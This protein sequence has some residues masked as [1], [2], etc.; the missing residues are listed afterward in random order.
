MVKIPPGIRRSDRSMRRSPGRSSAASPGPFR[1]A[2]RLAFVLSMT[3][4]AACD[5]DANAVAPSD[6][7]SVT[8]QVRIDGAPSARS[9]V[10]LRTPAG[11]TVARGNTDAQG[12]VT[13]EELE[14]GRYRILSDFPT[15]WLP[16]AGSAP[17]RLLDLE[18]GDAVTVS[19]R[20]ERAF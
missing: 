8:A 14:P 12:E 19:F 9:L 3:L 7:A 17:Q 6:T 4:P 2:A 15:I 13:F 5:D 1:S 16:A 11:V 10:L 20:Y 18:A